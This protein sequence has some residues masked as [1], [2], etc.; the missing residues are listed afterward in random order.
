MLGRTNERIGLFFGSFNPIHLGHLIIANYILENTDLNKIWFIVSPQNPLKNTNDLLDDTIR[1]KLVRLAIKNNNKFKASDIEFK[2]SKPS[3]TINTLKYLKSKHKTKDFVLI[4][5]E[6]NLDSFE[7]WKDYREILNDYELYVY[8]RT[9]SKA[10]KN[11][12]FQNIHKINAP[13][14]EISSTYIRENIKLNKS[15]RY[16]LPEVV[17]KEIEKNNYYCNSQD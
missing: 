12:N 13:L 14:I 16:L 2:L 4:V 8:P 10:N 1:L 11:L 15:I 9:N 5:G 6:D 17:R 3:Y 7:K